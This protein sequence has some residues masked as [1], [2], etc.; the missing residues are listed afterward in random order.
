MTSTMP[1]D[2]SPNSVEKESPFRP[3]QTIE[4]TSTDSI[5]VTDILYGS[6][7]ITDRVL[8][9]LIQD[10]SFQRLRGIH[11]HGITPVIHV[12]KV[13]PPVCRFEHSLGAML[14]I[15]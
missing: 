10:S 6:V 8:L 4:F 3:R 5:T 11:Q 15:R 12:N 2:P 1:S 9:S 13:N 7:A 14:L